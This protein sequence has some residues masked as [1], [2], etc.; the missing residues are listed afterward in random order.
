[1]QP[2]QLLPECIEGVEAFQRFDAT[3]TE[4]LSVP[5]STLV[6]RQKVYRRKVE[7]NPSRRGPK[8]KITASAASPDPAV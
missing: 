4:L 2:R 7:A 3:V 1:M 6:R 5:R 8:R